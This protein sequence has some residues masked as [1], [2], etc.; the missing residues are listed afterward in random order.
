MERMKHLVAPSLLAADFSRLADEIAL[1]NESDADWLHFDVMDG[2]FVPNI[3]FGLP[4]LKAVRKLSA[5]PIDVHLMIEHPERFVHDFREAGADVIT[6]HYEACT[7][8][9][10]TL[11]L[12]RDSGARAGVA[13]NPHTNV[14]LLED[15]LE[16]LDM[17]LVMSV[18]PGFG[19]QRFIYRTLTK[20]QALRDMLIVRNLPA[21]I[22]VDGGIGL[23]NAEKVL[24]AGADVLVAGSSVFRAES[25]T[26]VIHALKEL[27]SEVR[28]F[29]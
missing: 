18:N 11:Q 16:D 8:L 27:G 26:Q 6:V 23:Q 28:K 1:V 15:I 21:K 25:P 19:G 13:L 5:K 2:H 20:I 22:E 14:M 10:R 3:S 12:I 9:H 7:H 17:V 29:V 24:Q 4:V